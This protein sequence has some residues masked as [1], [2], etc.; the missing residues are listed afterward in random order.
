MSNYVTGKNYE[1]FVETVYRAIL[2][3][4]R[5]NGKIGH[6]QLE[7]RKKIISKSGTPAEIDIYW[8]YTIAGIKNCVAIECRNYNKNVDI[9]GVRDFARKISD[10]SGLKG[11][12]VTKRGFSENA[13]DEA[14]SDNI[15]L[16]VLREHQLEDWNG[17]IREIKIE[18]L[19]MS[20]SSTI[21]IDPKI[22]KDWAI[23]NGYKNGDPIRISS[24]NDL[25]IFE[26]RDNTFKHS[27]YELE[28]KDFFESKGPGR[29]T[30]CYDFKNGWMHTEEKSLK[31]DS[32]KIEY[33]KPEVVKNDLVINF[34]SCVL[35]VM[36]YISG[37]SGKYVI[38][39]SGERRG[40]EIE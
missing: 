26:D 23:E 13:I 10:I 6:I 30:W 2:E 36:D 37:D 11:L 5:R 14:R 35:A 38:M 34:E 12:M 17:Y 29:H 39:T 28:S 9:P 20:P 8:E 7:R 27:L 21:Q 40:Y 3:A 33:L 18:M 32:V 1:D 24:R 31:I 22:N 19:F 16:I 15:D 4:E 25:M